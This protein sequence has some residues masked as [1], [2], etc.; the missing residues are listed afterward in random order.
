ML[1]HYRVI[2]FVFLFVNSLQG[3]ADNENDQNRNEILFVKSIQTLG[4]TRS[5]GLAIAD[6]DKDGYKDVL[7]ANYIGP[8]RL[9]LNNGDGTFT[10]SNQAFYVS[11]IHD[12]GMD[13]LNGDTYP[14]VFLLSHASPSKVYFNNGDGTFT[15]SGQN[16]GIPSDSPGMIVLGDVDQDDDIDAFISYYGPPNRLW[17]ND[18]DGFF[19]VTDIEFGGS[20]NSASM[21]LN[22]FNGDLLPDLFLCMSDSPDQVWM[23]EG[24]GNFTNSG[25]ALGGIA[26]DG[27]PD[28]KDI[29]GDGDNDVVVANNV[30]GTITWL[31]QNNTGTF[32]QAGSYFG[33]PANRSK[34][35]DADLDGNFD[36]IT[37]HW[38]NGNQLWMN[39]GSGNFSSL[40]DLFGSSIVFS[41]GCD[42]LD[43]D[44]DIDVVFGQLEG[45]GGNSIY[46][47]ES[48][49]GIKDKNSIDLQNHELY[50]NFPNPFTQT[51]VVPYWVSN[52]SV[53]S[54]QV[55]DMFGRVVSILVDENQDSGFHQV[56]FD[57]KNLSSGI[58]LCKMTVH[59]SNKS[60]III[61][62]KK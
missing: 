54:I 46:F 52:R 7:I 48:I 56:E 36:L 43:E 41:I 21:A 5:F 59:G 35:F 10:Q 32:V 12:V 34:L 18:G 44:D 4:D 16:I 3:L 45:T 57:A 31:N 6:V 9:W 2:L 8:S 22:D 26:G 1:V 47:N 49:V 40:G 20:G 19:T 33:E 28:S 55:F 62:Q 14:D 53:I 27:N 50:P 24:N 29:D 42:D 61:I 51:T 38:D 39:D 58:Y 13:D 17:L 25:Q 60:S 30:E 23:N 37:T 11:E 15:D